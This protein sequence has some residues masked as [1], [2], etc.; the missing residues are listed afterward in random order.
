MKLVGAKRACALEDHGRSSGKEKLSSPWRQVAVGCG[1]LFAKTAAIIPLPRSSPTCSVT[2]NS[3]HLETKSP[4]P[5]LDSGRPRDA[6]DRTRIN[7][8]VSVLSLDLDV[9]ARC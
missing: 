7:D 1:R 9:S 4:G 6:D 2:F 5:A 8:T 3:S